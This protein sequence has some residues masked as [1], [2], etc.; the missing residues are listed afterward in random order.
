M[1]ARFRVR[2]P[3]RWWLAAQA[4]LNITDPD[5]RR[6]RWPDRQERDWAAIAVAVE[7]IGAELAAGRPSSRLVHDL[8]RKVDRLGR[9]LLEGLTVLN[10]LSG[11]ASASRW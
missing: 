1:Q 5:E 11:A 2:H 7:A 8:G 3:K 4:D 6:P 9:N 10:D